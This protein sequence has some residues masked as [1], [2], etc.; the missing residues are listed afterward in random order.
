MD[1]TG[2]DSVPKIHQRLRRLEYGN[3]LLGSNVVWRKAVLELVEPGCDKVHRERIQTSSSDG[4]PRSNLPVDAG[5][6]AEG[7]N[8][9]THI[10]QLNPDARQTHPQSRHF[11]ENRP[12]QVNIVSSQS[13]VELSIKLYRDHNCDYDYYYYEDKYY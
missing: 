5:L 7:E 2:S 10:F 13:Y 9:P 8:P 11:E 12:E 3:C 1:G 6:L 4:L